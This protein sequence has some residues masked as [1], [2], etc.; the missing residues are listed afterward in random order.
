V[1]YHCFGSE[2]S[3]TFSIEQKI[4]NIAVLNLSFPTRT[5]SGV[6]GDE[7]ESAFLDIATFLGGHGFQPCHQDYL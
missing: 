7:E 3:E 6:E 5:L 1:D 4:E 2:V